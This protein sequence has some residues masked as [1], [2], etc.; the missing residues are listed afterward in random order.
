MSSKI[1][2]TLVKKEML[3]VLR[4][5]KTVLMMLVVPIILYPLIFIGVM[6]VMAMISS[7]MEDQTYRIAIRSETEDAFLEQRLQTAGEE[8]DILVELADASLIEDYE[9][10]LNEEEID[11]YVVEQM[12]DGKVSYTLYYL[13]S[14]TNSAYALDV[15]EDM[16]EEYKEDIRVQKIE[17]AGL[18]ADEILEPVVYEETDIAST[19]QSLGSIMGMILPF[20]L[21]VSL[22][23]GTMYPAIDT[24]AGE[25]ERGTLETI[26]TLPVTNR[27]L[28]ISKFLTVAAIGLVS[29]A[30]N[31]VSMS[32]I[33]FYMYQVM[34]LTLEE[35]VSIAWGSFIPVLFVTILAILAFS[36]FIS[37]ITM[38]VTAFAKSYKEANNYI[39]PLLLVFMLTG[40]IAFI[41]NVELTRTMAMVPVANISL[42][43]KN[44]MAFKY[45][46]A[47]ITIVVLSNVA[48]AVLAILFLSKIYDSESILFG[49]GKGG[50]QL[51]EKRSNMK[52]GGVPDVSDAWFMIALTIVMMLYLG[53]MLQ[54]RFGIGG[55]FGTQMILLLMPF[56][57]VWY[58]KRDVK[59]TYCFYKAKP[60]AYLGA[61]LMIPGMTVLVMI[62]SVF[63]M[64]LFP[65][66]AEAVTDAFG[67]IMSGNVWI[68][69]AVISITPAICEEMLFRGFI[70]SAMRNRYRSVTA[71]LIVAALFGVYHMSLV[72]FFTTGLLGLV[73]CYIVYLTDSIF[74]AML[75]HCVNNLIAVLLSYT[76]VSE[77]I[78]RVF[79]ILYEEEFAV[80][81]VLLL[82]GF[83][84]L[85]TVLG[86]YVIKKWGTERISHEHVG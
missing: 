19:E 82:S 69:I 3:D 38:C 21:I 20:M 32:G 22:L 83:G 40:Y 9:T 60:A 61:F 75:M 16:L 35:G 70:F 23:M 44:L 34:D 30:L 62:L 8:N 55:L 76:P 46:Y 65:G 63:L 81:D 56:L 11:V 54:L 48:Y 15:V 85:M 25:R 29:A 50:M 66:S 1:I 27:Q 72:K 67:E 28:I 10:A 6:Q 36:L 47:I 13:S 73:F 7:S 52:K 33:A 12:Q 78:S 74:P 5:K 45:D 64:K 18:N 37:A 24:T 53:S 39:T 57:F 59:R 2:K 26:L 41:P 49:D 42:L 31:I 77:R 14:V 71:M 80:S 51:L 17:A 68:Q 86:F 79:P 4:D 58:T 43:L 84:I